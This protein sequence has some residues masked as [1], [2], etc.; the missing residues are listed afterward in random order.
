M[1][2]GVW[3][4]WP[5]SER[6]QDQGDG[7]WLQREEDGLTT[8]TGGLQEPGHPHCHR[9]KTNS[10]AVYKKIGRKSRSFNRCSRLWLDVVHQSVELHCDCWGSSN[11]NT[12]YRLIKKSGSSI[13]CKPDAFEAVLERRTLNKVLPMTVN[14]EPQTADWSTWT[15]TGSLSPTPELCLTKNSQLQSFCLKQTALRSDPSITNLHTPSLHHCIFQQS[16]DAFAHVLFIKHVMLFLL[17]LVWSF[18]R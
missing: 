17:Q 10:E 8:P 13:G 18:S 2:C 14:P 3:K 5:P 1:V 7:D 9:L 15:D 11:T 16:F 12:L 4:K 6:G